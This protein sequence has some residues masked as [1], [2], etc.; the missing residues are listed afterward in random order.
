MAEYFSQTGLTQF[1][2]TENTSSLKGMVNFRRY[3][4]KYFDAQLGASYYASQSYY[5]DMFTPANDKRYDTYTVIYGGLLLKLNKGLFG[6][7]GGG[8]KGSRKLACPNVNF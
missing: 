2:F 1:K 4:N 8:K 7:G 3:L 5:L 6:L